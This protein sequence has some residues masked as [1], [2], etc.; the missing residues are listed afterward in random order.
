MVGS[1]VRCDDGTIDGDGGG[2]GGNSDDHGGGPYVLSYDINV[3]G[4]RTGVPP[5]G[6]SRLRRLR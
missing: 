2:A 5:G 1:P 6:A 4:T 3:E